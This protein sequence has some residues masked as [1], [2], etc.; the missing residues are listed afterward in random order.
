MEENIMST[1][2]FQPYKIKNI[3]LKNRIVMSPMCMYSSTGQQGF[4]EDFHMTHY[5]SRAV[6]QVG[7][8]MVEATAVTPQGRISALDLG[9][10]RNEHLPQLKKLVD[11]M[12]QYGA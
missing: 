8:I 7:L 4:V 10:W 5:I 6:G 12:K 9:I 11:G 1:K 3:T 2:L